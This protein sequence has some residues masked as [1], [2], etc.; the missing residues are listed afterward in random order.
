MAT[1]DLIREPWVPVVRRGRAE[2]VSLR[3]CLLDAHTIDGLAF[4]APLEMVAVL[5]QVLLPVYLDAMFAAPAVGDGQPAPPPAD[6]DEWKTLWDRTKD[7]L[8][9]DRLDAYLAIHTHRFDLFGQ[10]PFAQV[11]GLRT[12]TG[13]GDKTKP[14]S[15]LIASASSGNN[16]PLFSARTE[17][18]PP[19]LSPAAA[20]RALLAAQCWDTAGIKSGVEGDPQA[21]AGKTTGNRTGPLGALGVVVPQGSTLAET[22]LLNTPIMSQ[23]FPAADRPQWRAAASDETCP[24]RPAWSQRSP[25]GLLDLLTWQARRIRLVPEE[26]AGDGPVVRR[27]VLAAGDRLPETPLMEPH[28]GWKLAQGAKVATPDRHR[29]GRAAWR[30]LPALLAT[31]PNASGTVTSPRV[32]GD[33]RRLQADGCLPNDLPVQVRTVGVRYGTQSAVVEDVMSD[34]IPLPL[35][36]LDPAGPVR[37]LLDEVVASAERLREAANRF[38]DDLRQASGGDKLPWDRGQRLGDGLI[39]EYT[40]VVRRLL[41][42]LQHEPDRW[43]EADDAWRFSARRRALALIE[44]AL[45]ATPPRAFLGSTRDKVVRRAN[46]AEARYRSSV[47]EAVPAPQPPPGMGDA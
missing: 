35:V 39:S 22:L 30:G 1:F 29:P 9:G 28:T 3:E 19:A 40:P 43:E 4:E 2:M 37:E 24:G 31:T 25:L 34:Q 10:Q 47:N 33:I 17:S 16:V 7:R 26:G 36:A 6:V 41:A 20:A 5:R 27:V 15:L 45:A 12:G 46:L 38:G 8:D 21:R 32:L 11:A 42:G 18:D 14:V 13:E 44:P 23:P